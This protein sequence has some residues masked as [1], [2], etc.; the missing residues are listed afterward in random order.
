M[1]LRTGFTQK[2]RRIAVTTPL[3][4]DVL[5]LKAFSGHEAMSRLC[6]FD[7]ELLSENDSINFDDVIGQKVSVKVLLADRS[8]R[9]W[10]G[11]VSRFSQGSRDEVLTAYHAEMVPWL[12]F[13]T[14]TADCR[15]FQNKS[16]P[17]IIE[18]IFADLGVSD[19]ALRLYGSFGPREYC[20]QRNIDNRVHG[21][22]A[23][24][25]ILGTL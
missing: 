17:D 6:K 24:H 4:E 9:Y 18:Q 21:R 14:R 22:T 20:V 3:G 16:V 7:L 13:L 25:R 19:Y 15:I 23:R 1:A 5:L 10:H 2:N 8:E 12:W 11:H